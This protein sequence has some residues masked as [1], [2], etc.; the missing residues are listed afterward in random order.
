MP[1]RNNGTNKTSIMVAG[2]ALL[3]GAG[4]A[5]KL[6]VL[7]Q[8]VPNQQKT[9]TVVS[10]AKKAKDPSV[11][12]AQDV[13]ALT[14]KGAAARRKKQGTKKA[15]PKPSQPS[16]SGGK[17][18]EK[19]PGNAFDIPT[20]DWK[21]GRMT[22]EQIAKGDVEP[23]DDET[24]LEA[25]TA[26]E[27][28]EYDA[29][30]WVERIKSA[31]SKTSGE[32][33]EMFMLKYIFA[34]MPDA[35]QTYFAIGSKHKEANAVSLKSQGWNGFVIDS[36][37][38]TDTIGSIIERMQVPSRMGL[39]SI[40]FGSFDF[41]VLQ[42]VLK[43]TMADVLL[44]DFNPMWGPQDLYCTPPNFVLTSHC[45]FCWGSSLLAFYDLLNKQEYDY[46]LVGVSP[47]SHSAFF[48]RGGLL[49]EEYRLKNRLK[50]HF[51]THQKRGPCAAAMDKYKEEVMRTFACDG[52]PVKLLT[53]K[54]IDLMVNICRSYKPRS[55]S[56]C[57]STFD[58]MKHCRDHPSS[59]WDGAMFS[60]GSEILPSQGGWA[61][62]VASAGPP[63]GRTGIA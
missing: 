34:H 31:A 61:P 29:L 28:S 49:T 46:H 22:L 54:E 58:K 50:S 13:L 44:L 40:G 21:G 35:P 30:H 45:E 14:L 4:L 26:G 33:R 51:A 38:R 6:L 7:S 36:G 41:F 17:E 16:Q 10:E 48:M 24:G 20:A 57:A 27:D 9:Q 63:T 5:M 47:T 39:L 59:I 18:E 52:E 2:C 56:I 32:S 8:P 3:G 42:E 62:Q 55:S 60:D 37:V 19:G 15:K 12:K 23:A 53:C 43:K 1:K 25:M 11:A